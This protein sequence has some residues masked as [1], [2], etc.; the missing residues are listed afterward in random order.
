M[1]HNVKQ[2]TADG[3][4]GDDEKGILVEITGERSE[5]VRLTGTQEQVEIASGRTAARWF[6]SIS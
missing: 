3:I 1:L 4:F 2:F 6:A 5:A